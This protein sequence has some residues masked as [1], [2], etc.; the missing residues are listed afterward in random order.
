MSMIFIIPPPMVETFIITHLT[1]KFT[2]SNYFHSTCCSLTT[3]FMEFFFMQKHSKCRFTSQRIV[4]LNERLLQHDDFLINV[5]NEVLFNCKFLSHFDSSMYYFINNKINFQI[6]H[7]YQ[8][9][10]FH[11]WCHHGLNNLLLLPH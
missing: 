5:K 6:L 4:S 8:N 3:I 2:I 9:G 10:K 11:G 7:I 1:R